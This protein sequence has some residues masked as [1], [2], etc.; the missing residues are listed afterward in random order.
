MYGE[1]AFAHVCN[2]A[3]VVPL[4]MFTVP[5]PLDAL[6]VGVPVVK[7]CPSPLFVFV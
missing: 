6:A 5:A 2:S 1:I 4:Q 3:G 7:N